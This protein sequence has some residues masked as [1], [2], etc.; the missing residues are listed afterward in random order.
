MPSWAESEE[1]SRHDRLVTEIAR[2]RFAYPNIE[3][4]AYV[5]YTNEPTQRMG[6]KTG[7]S[8]VYPDIVVVDASAS[9]NLEL[10]GE[11]ETEATI[12]Q[13]HVQQWRT[14]SGLNA[15][16]FLYVPSSLVQEARRLLSSN[17]V[18]LSGG[19]RSYSD[20]AQGNLLI[21]SL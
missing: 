5:T 15:S 3:H 4:P 11:V 9:N 21:T 10:I 14:Y 16:F 2:L 18:N 17:G 7:S 12:N 19:L 8:V 20:D 13:D 6:V 1:K